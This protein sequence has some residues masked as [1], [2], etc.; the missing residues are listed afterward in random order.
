MTSP[1]TKTLDP[2]RKAAILIS[3]LDHR[4]ADELL[5]RMSD[6]QAALVREAAMEMDEIPEEEQKLVMQ[7][8][9]GI[10]DTE[11]SD[12]S[13]NKIDDEGIELDE[14]LARKIA[15]G[16]AFDTSPRQ[17][18]VDHEPPFRFLCDADAATIAKHLADE[19]PQIIAV[20][21]AHLPPRPAAELLQKFEPVLQANLMRRVAELDTA[22][23]DIVL[24]VE[25]HLQML[26]QD[27]LRAAK[28]RALGLSTV[29]S[30]LSAAGGSRGQLISSLTRHDRQLAHQ[31]REPHRHSIADQHALSDH[32]AAVGSLPRVNHSHRAAR[33]D[34]RQQSTNRP[35][36]DSP[37]L[38]I[39]HSENTDKDNTISF[40]FD[41]L[42]HLS[43]SEL[44][45]VFSRSDS[46]LTML[47]LAGAS[48]QLVNRLLKQLPNR[49]AKAFRKRVDQLGA[50][51]LSDIEHAQAA[52]AHI[53]AKLITDG[54]IAPPEIE[55]IAVAA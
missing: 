21:L 24:E 8:F 10:D 33:D 47:A 29:S 37:A 42:T 19:N 23:R 55:H 20:V 9:M 43:N 49:E 38:R 2:I 18:I 51:R 5:E 7:E 46:K 32:K 11:A 48:P 27:E 53:A 50:V 41:E 35:M 52:I 39:H 31:L 14:E 36:N 54:E 16:D 34:Q 26:L 6:E 4:V 45:L 40:H 3:T 1:N 30:I 25:R 12:A 15:E 44:A 17:A 13:I 28:N 22:D